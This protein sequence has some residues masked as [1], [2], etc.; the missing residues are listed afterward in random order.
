MVA[1]SLPNISAN[2]LFECLVTANIIFNLFTSFF[3][4]HYYKTSKYACKNT[5]TNSEKGTIFSK[6]LRGK[7][8]IE[9][10]AI[11][12]LGLIIIK[13]ERKRLFGRFLNY[14]LHRDDINII[15]LDYTIKRQNRNKG[16]TGKRLCPDT[17][18]GGGQSRFSC[19]KETGYSGR[20]TEMASSSS[21]ACSMMPG[22]S[23]ITSRPLLFLGKAIQ[24]RMLSRPAKRLTKR[25]R[26]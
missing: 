15:S 16:Q 2:H 18:V 14:Y 13:H 10:F 25:S 20:L 6:C 26:P 5:I 3:A 11:L 4:I 22:A 24:S 23:S 1:W 21:W 19:G 12:F 8:I 9:Y 17:A 7:Q